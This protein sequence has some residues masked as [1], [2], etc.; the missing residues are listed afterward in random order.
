MGFATHLGPWL[1]GTVKNTTGTTAG[2]IRNTGCS[3]VSQQATLGFA[4]GATNVF[5][6]PAGSLITSIQL[7]TTTGYAGGTTPTITI[8][9]GATTIT[10]GLTNPSAA[11]VSA[12]TIATTGAPFV[13]NVGTTDA[14]ITATLAGTCTSGAS[15]LVIAYVV[16]NSDGG[17]F[18]TT[19]NN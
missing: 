10:S 7:I 8:S 9:S 12:F 18:Q 11:G 2:S 16:R 4:D 14:I 1:L 17:Q 6:L 19:Y 3:I 15:T 13:N 5:T